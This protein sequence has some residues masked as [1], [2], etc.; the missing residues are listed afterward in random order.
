[1]LPQRPAAAEAKAEAGLTDMRTKYI[2]FVPEGAGPFL[3]VILVIKECRLSE[4]VL[5][6]SSQ[7]LDSRG[8]FRL[9][10]GT[11]KTT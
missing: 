1:M 9:K 6:T 8:D 3:L 7:R 4:Q 11:S 2:V 10:S 5:I